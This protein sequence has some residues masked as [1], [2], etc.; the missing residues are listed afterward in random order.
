MNKTGSRLSLE[1]LLSMHIAELDIPQPQKQYIFHPERN[2]KLDFAWPEYKLALELEGWGH[3]TKKRF[4]ED[5]I[6]Y[7]ELSL[8]GWCLLRVN[9][10]MVKKSTEGK[11]YVKRFFEEVLR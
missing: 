2:W 4:D 10:D 9:T 1:Y 6:K 5:I 3:R 7:N 8:M 11:Q